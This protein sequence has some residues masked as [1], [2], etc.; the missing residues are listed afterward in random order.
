[1]KSLLRGKIMALSTLIKKL[2][3]SYISKLIE[4]NSPNMTRQQEILRAKINQIKTKRTIQRINKTKNWHFEKIN[5]ID[6]SLAKLSKWL[7]GINKI[8]KEKG[9]I[10]SETEEI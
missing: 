6:K 9:D 7:R 5:K 2:E 10:T 3:R 4:A 1:M 8:R